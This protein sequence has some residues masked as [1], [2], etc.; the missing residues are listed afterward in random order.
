[1]ENSIV[2]SFEIG[3]FIILFQLLTTALQTWIN[4]RTIK[5]KFQEEVAID[6]QWKTTVNNK[7]DSIEKSVLSIDEIKNATLSNR[8]E[9]EKMKLEYEFKL[10]Q[11][12]KDISAVRTE[13]KTDIDKLFKMVNKTPNLVTE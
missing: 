11:T 8:I 2:I 13:L 5:S 6:T 4:T 10:E 7:L 1:M 9:I 3:V 12:N